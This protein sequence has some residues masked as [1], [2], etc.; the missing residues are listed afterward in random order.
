MEA[1]MASAPKTYPMLQDGERGIRELYLNM[2]ATA[3]EGDLVY[4]ENQYFFD[5]GIVSEIHEAAQRGAKI[6]VVLTSKPDE[7]STIIQQVV[8]KVLEKIT[9]YED[10]FTLVKGHENVGIFTLGNSRPDPRDEGKVINSETYVHSK[11]M[12]VIGNYWAIMTGG[13]ANIAFT[14]TWF[15]S[16]MNIAFT[17][18]TRI[19]DW[20]AKLWKEHLQIS[21]DRAKELIEK[22]DDALGFFKAQAVLNKIAMERGKMPE[23]RVY[24]KGTV[25]PREKVGRYQSG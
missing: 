2:L 5:H 11:N 19:K 3:D 13:S 15:H 12:A 4:I 7:D 8:E 22:P 23:G 20:V 1:K 17:D 14:S 21:I 18:I 10:I 9:S 25:F 6:I 16:E 24:Q